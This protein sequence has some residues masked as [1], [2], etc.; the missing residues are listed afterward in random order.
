MGIEIERKFLVAG[1]GWRAAAH[2]P[3]F[4]QVEICA[5]DIGAIQNDEK[6]AIPAFF[7]THARHAACTKC[8]IRQ[9][10]TVR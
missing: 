8:R 10:N 6:Y 1:D 9:K 3:I 2:A 4:G 7:K 5:A